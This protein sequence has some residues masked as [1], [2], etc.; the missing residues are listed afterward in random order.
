LPGAFTPTGAV[1]VTP[2]IEAGPAQF[3]LS[4]FQ[5]FVP[6]PGATYND[7]A[8]G[9]VTAAGSMSQSLSGVDART[10][11]CVVSGLLSSES[12]VHFGLI[13]FNDVSALPIALTG[14]KTQS[15]SHTVS[16]TAVV[17]LVFQSGVAYP[18][19]FYPGQVYP[20]QSTGSVAESIAYGGSGL[21]LTRSPDPHWIRLCPPP[22]RPGRLLSGVAAQIRRPIPQLRRP[23]S[24][25]LVRQTRTTRSAAA[26]PSTTKPPAQFPLLGN[27]HNPIP[28]RTHVQPRSFSSGQ[29]LLPVSSMSSGSRIRTATTGSQKNYIPHL[30]SSVGL[31][32]GG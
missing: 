27:D 6:D 3:P 17:S 29:A 10:G 12:N 26:E 13:V 20:G 5:S 22:L 25:F 24:S 31:G 32:H 1:Q 18:G 14:S 30:P 21:G 15:A 23:Q 7:T 19:A 8:A 28:I 4:S 9:V 2:R 11:A 16:G